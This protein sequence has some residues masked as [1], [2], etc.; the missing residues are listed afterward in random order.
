MVKLGF[1][2]ILKEN[3]ELCKTA[4]ELCVPYF[5]ELNAHDGIVESPAKISE[6]IEHRIAIQG[7]REN[8]HFEIAFLKDIPVGVA[9]FAI[10]LG[11]VRGMLESGYGTVMEFYIRPEYRRKGYG[12]AFLQHIED[13]LCK[14]GANRFYITPDSVTGIPF[15]KSMG[16][17]D[18]GL[19]D[20]DNKQ[21]IFIKHIKTGMMF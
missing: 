6:A 19:I 16:Y 20:P 2:Q 11:T 12:E 17:E 1:V 9:M 5:E 3:E 8:M 18:S 13:T 7:T 10:D 4:K 14:D 21:P 15:W